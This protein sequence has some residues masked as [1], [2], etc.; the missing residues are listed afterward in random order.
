MCPT[1]WVRSKIDFTRVKFFGK[2]LSSQS[3][4]LVFTPAGIPAR[5]EF[6]MFSQIWFSNL[7]SPICRSWQTSSQTGVLIGIS[8]FYLWTLNI[9]SAQNLASSCSSQAKRKRSTRLRWITSGI[10]SRLKLLAESNWFD[11]RIRSFQVDLWR[12]PHPKWQSSDWQRF[13]AVD[14]DELIHFES[15]HC[16][17]TYRVCNTNP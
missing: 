6:A 5:K 17:W 8:N 1:W 2:H 10:C 11:S 15:A 3:T 7:N 9:A 13:Q 14:S 16:F 4:R 12:F